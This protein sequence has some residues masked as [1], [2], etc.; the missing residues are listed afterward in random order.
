MRTASIV[1]GS[2]D[3]GVLAPVVSVGELENGPPSTPAIGVAEVGSEN[4]IA[5][6]R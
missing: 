3:T 2:G 4:V 5:E 1:R 6:T